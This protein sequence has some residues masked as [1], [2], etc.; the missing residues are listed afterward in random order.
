[1]I[2]K[3]TELYSL[4]T[5]EQKAKLFRLQ[6]LIILMSV[7]EV[8]GV[9][10]FGSLMS[11]VGET[12]ILQSD[13]YLAEIYRHSNFSQ[14]ANFIFWLAV[15]VLIILFTSSVIAV[16]TVWRL[17]MF[18]AQIGT[19]LAIVCLATIYINPGYFTR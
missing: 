15:A 13:S 3:L 10:A 6:A 11:V 4:L 17:S 5:R 8:S 19:E 1:M 18:S 14:P 16:I 2:S 7:A 12:D 9:L